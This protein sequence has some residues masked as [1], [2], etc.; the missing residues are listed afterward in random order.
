MPTTLPLNFERDLTVFTVKTRDCEGFI[1][2]DN[3]TKM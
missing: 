2:P 1:Q 3:P